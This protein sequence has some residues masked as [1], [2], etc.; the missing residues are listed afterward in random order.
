MGGARAGVV[1]ACNLGCGVSLTYGCSKAHE[2]DE[3]AEKKIA[4]S[5]LARFRVSHIVF[6][7]LLMLAN[8]WWRWWRWRATIVIKVR[9][10]DIHH[11][12]A[13][14]GCVPKHL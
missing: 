9:G 14:C 1:I 12:P 5:V 4:R 2:E 7:R 8:L 11:P 10:L 3:E 6:M 13:T